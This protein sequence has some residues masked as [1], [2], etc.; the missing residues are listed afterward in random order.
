MKL[1]LLLFLLLNI[2]ILFVSFIT[3]AGC[4]HD[5]KVM[6]VYND[7]MQHSIEHVLEEQ[8]K[9]ASEM[10]QVKTNSDIVLRMVTEGMFLEEEE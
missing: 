6:Q 5:L 7:R 3:A 10:R 4:M 1:K 2:L 8:N 9:Q